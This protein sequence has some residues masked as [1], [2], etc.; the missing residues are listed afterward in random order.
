[1]TPTKAKL[2]DVQDW[3]T[4]EDVKGVRSFLGFTNYYQM[5]VQN[6]VAIADPLILQMRTNVELQWRPYQRSGFQQLKEAL[7]AV[8]ILLI[9]DPKLPYIVVTNAFG[10]AADGVLMQDQGDW[11]QPLAFPSKRLKPTEQRYSVY[12]RELAIVA[13]CLQ[14]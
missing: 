10:V 9:L 11:L 14:S 13:Y 6:F 8:P 3:A 2:K 4:L 12:E 1:M 7:C 5:F